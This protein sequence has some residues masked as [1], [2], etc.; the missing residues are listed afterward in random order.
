MSNQLKF[1][2]FQ[3]L[4]NCKYCYNQIKE[5]I[6]L[7]CGASVCKSHSEDAIKPNCYFCNE[8]HTRPETGFMPNGI[9]HEMLDIEVNKLTFSPKFVKCQK[10]INK[11]LNDAEKL[12]CIQKDPANYIYEYFEELKT[13]TDLRREQLKLEIDT[14]SDELITEINCIQDNCCKMTNDMK[15]INK[16]IDGLKAELDA[17]VA[18]FDSFEFDDEKYDSIL[19]ET[20]ALKPKIDD[21]TE[22]FKNFL[23]GNKKYIFRYNSHID[24][25]K[26]YGSIIAFPVYMV[27]IMSFS[28][29]V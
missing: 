16:V 19:T 23:T 22:D 1:E 24:L 10:E 25:K 27:Y 17:L 21:Y 26:F 5:P 14:F 11:I 15:E 3:A 13:Q 6:I 12:F 28:Y 18:R 4:F 29:D 2:K 8:P 9:L 7:P 20:V